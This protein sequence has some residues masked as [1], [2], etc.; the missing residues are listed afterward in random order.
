MEEELRNLEQK[1]ARMYSDIE[2]LSSVS[3]LAYKNFG[4]VCADIMI[5]KKKITNRVKDVF[6]E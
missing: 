4:K 2:S 3:D 1:K 5:L 6:E